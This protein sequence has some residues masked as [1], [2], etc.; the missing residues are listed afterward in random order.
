MSKINRNLQRMDALNFLF[1]P[2]ITKST[3]MTHT[4]SLMYLS[5]GNVQKGGGGGGGCL[6]GLKPLP[7]FQNY[8]KVPPLRQIAMILWSVKT[9]AMLNYKLT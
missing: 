3:R 8:S 5:T 9:N 4:T 2:I 7:L 6:L 1:S